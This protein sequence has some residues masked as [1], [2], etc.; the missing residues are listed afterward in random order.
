M[1]RLGFIPQRRTQIVRLGALIDQDLGTANV[2]IDALATRAIALQN[3]MLEDE[4]QGIAVPS[5]LHDEIMHISDID[6]DVQAL[7]ARISELD[8]HDLAMWLNTAS[9]LGSR[10]GQYETALVQLEG[11]GAT[12]TIVQ[13][14]VGTVLA[15]GFAAGVTYWI[16]KKGRHS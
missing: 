12:R 16:K 1:M 13:L 6:G 10:I 11:S 15:V 8:H 2:T 5:S 9:A 7:E 14:A 4:R 3:R